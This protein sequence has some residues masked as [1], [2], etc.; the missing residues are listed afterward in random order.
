[1]KAIALLI[2]TLV[3]LSASVEAAPKPQ[4]P[5]NQVDRDISLPVPTT[6]LALST[7]IKEDKGP[8]L[9]SFEFAASAWSPK[10]FSRPTYTNGRSN[11]ERK[12]LPFLSINRH[13]PLY[14]FDNLS[15]F[16][17]KLGLSFTRLERQGQ[18]TSGSAFVTTQTMN[19]FSLRIGAEYQGPLYLGDLLQPYAGLSLLPTLALSSQSQ[20]EGSVSRIGLPLEAVGGVM[21]YPGFLRAFAGMTNGAIGLGAHYIFG[22]VDNSKMN[23]L[24]AQGF[25]RLDI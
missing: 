22:T 16:H 14:L 9:A 19:L 4:A 10:G 13:G 5:E 23:D 12:G 2:L 20:M 6:E 18:F 8:T 21:A 7:K 17:S 3:T 1:M 25:L 15:G 11:F 24:G